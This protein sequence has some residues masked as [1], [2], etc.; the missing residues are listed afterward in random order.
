[1][2]LVPAKRCVRLAVP[3]IE[4]DG[5]RRI[6]QGSLDDVRRKQHSLTRAVQR[7]A[8]F[9][10]PLPQPRPA[11]LDADLGQNA[12]GVGEDALDLLDVRIWSWDA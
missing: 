3:I 11:H 7:Q 1:M 4:R 2:H 12:F 5:S 10:Q 9:Q 8:K 6:G